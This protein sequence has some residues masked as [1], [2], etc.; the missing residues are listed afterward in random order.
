MHRRLLTLSRSSLLALSTTILA[1][2]LAGLLTIGQ[3]WSLSRVVDGV[4]L[5]GQTLA[6][7]LPL[8]QTLLALIFGRGLLA[9]LG[10]V[11]ANA[12]AVRVKTDLR[13]R[14][15]THILRL[16]PAYTRSQRTGELTAAAVEG[17]EALDAYFSQYLPQL[18]TSALV[19]VT[20][21]AFV[22][23]NDLLSAGI[24]LVTAPLIPFFMVLVGKTAEALTK[25]QW[26]TL[27]LLSAH[28]LDSLQGLTTLKLFGQSKAHTARIADV[29]GRFRDTT[30]DVLRITFLSALV[31][32]LLTTLSTAILA[33]EIGFRLLYA[34][35]EFQPALFLLI[36]APEFYLPLRMLGLRFHAGMAGTS[37]ARRIYEILET[38]EQGQENSRILPAEPLFST[39]H[40]SNLSYTYPGETMPALQDINLTIQAGQRVALV[41]KTG[42]GKS[43]LVNLLLGFI[44]PSSG[45][46][47]T[48]HAIISNYQLPITNNQPHPFIAW[49]PQHPY[50]F[51]DTLAAN[52]K[53]GKPDAT[54]EQV[55]AAA[56]AARLDE[57]IA[58][59][60]DGY[61]TRVG[62]GGARLSGGQAQR[63]AL[64][65]AFLMDAPLLILDEPT[66]S[67]DPETESQ[68]DQAIREPGRSR[69]VIT[70][71][72]RLNTVFDADKIVVLEAGR[73][74]ETGTHD[75][76]LAKNGAYARLVQA[77][78]PAGS[79]PGAVPPARADE[80]KLVQTLVTSSLGDAISPE[81]RGPSTH[82]LLRRLLGFLRGSWRQ[83]G[84]SVLLG[85]ATIGS[86]VALMGTSAWLIST[87]ALHGS[88][89]D[90]GV[91]VVGVRFF[92]IARG[93]FRYL[94]RLVSHGVTF[95]L[96]ARLRV[97]FYRALEPLAPARLMRFRSGDLLS[98][99]VADVE[100]LE[101][102]Y[103]RVISPPVVAALVGLGTG[104]F[105]WRYDTSLAL[106]LLASLLALGVGT[107]FI[108]QALSRAPGR[109]LIARR[110]A[111]HT[112]LVDGI[113]GLPDL[114][115]FG[116]AA[117]RAA[118]IDAASRDYGRIQQRMAA[119][120]A[121]NTG[122]GTLLSN[123]G[124][125]TVVL[126]AI[127]LIRQGQIPGVMLATLGLVTL[128]AFEAVTPLPLAAQTMS[129]SAEAARRLFDV[130]D[131]VPGVS[132]QYPV[133]SDQPSITNYQLQI[134]DLTFT[135]PNS[136]AP[137]LQHLT[138][139]LRPGESVAIVGPSGAGKSTLVNL[140]MRFRDYRQG[141]IRLDG[142]D[143]REME[144]D[145]ARARFAVVAQNSYF[146]NASIRQNLKLAR[147]NASDEEM[148]EA[149]RQAQIHEWIAG[150]KD[151]YGTRIG[152][153]GFRL[154]GGERQRLAIA[155]A[156]LKDAP[157]LVLDEPTA[158]LDPVTE[159]AVLETL[160]R[161]MAGRTS[162]L[163]THRL[164]GLENAGTI[165]VLDQ[166]RIV[167]QG[168]HE[169]LLARDGLYRRLYD[170]QNR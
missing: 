141:R 100:I 92:G 134:A 28:F 32:E 154:S 106:A 115:A 41:G 26:D 119:I 162:I 43:T 135:Y 139:D 166:G 54:R 112:L 91:A 125:W 93:V 8:M 107:P 163:I 158:N 133:S 19:P 146:F 9:W 81:Y 157:I 79:P 29:A 11:S 71:A 98:R 96:L 167:E 127:P 145:E 143:L 164:V 44:Q 36:L 74:V 111:L 77:L 47:I 89:A 152:E 140:L 155:R 160:F 87:A 68:L 25:R 126:L 88:V 99:V 120:N 38:G 123:L 40:L 122:L 56:R 31:L 60:E 103:I 153:R 30:L 51:N 49:V 105:L 104:L 7:V 20:I 142:V 35:M 85:A 95:N 130:V 15:F 114:L 84:L 116:R 53:L 113:Q 63:L 61:E 118:Q 78:A 102:F 90:F 22:I 69:T 86:S 159:R 57:F 136:A 33:V 27:S 58:S 149:A 46:I 73:I 48:Q 138:F 70:I 137:A 150:L 10:E 23:P 14:L 83:V 169:A 67:L 101:N 129:S 165:L 64:A 108:T 128:A 132:E 66:S 72:H 2:L 109:E 55:V 3:S 17:I 170:L 80:Q 117:D 50:L 110:A 5:G 144:Q 148:F 94:E 97:W 75:E 161:L 12:V 6:Q 168:R 147:P 121:V 16:G 18:V 156:L 42:A 124:L 45:Q 65:R 13:Q 34:R 82:R 4:F 21:L 62:E 151:G 131:E 59:L 37:A 24:L 52:I 39:L 76:L 1:G